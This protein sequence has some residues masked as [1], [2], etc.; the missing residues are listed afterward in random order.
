LKI[1]QICRR[2]AGIESRP[3]WVARAKP[4]RLARGTGEFTT[5]LEP[6]PGGME[7]DMPGDEVLVKRGVQLLEEVGPPGFHN[8]DD[9]GQGALPVRDMMEDPE[10]EYRIHGAV[11]EGERVR[12]GR[13]EV[14]A[15]LDQ[16]AGDP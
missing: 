5:V 2:V 16:A 7:Q 6:V 13:A 9:L 15:H 11:C 3:T 4:E 12:I 8:P 14:N 10:A 1:S